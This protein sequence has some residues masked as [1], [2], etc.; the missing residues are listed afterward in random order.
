[1]VHFNGLTDPNSANLLM[2][3]YDIGVS[4]LILLFSSLETGGKGLQCCIREGKPPL[5]VVKAV[6]ISG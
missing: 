5:P 3:M 4:F 6:N 2:E 1:M